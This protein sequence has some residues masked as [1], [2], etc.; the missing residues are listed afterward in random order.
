MFEEGTTPFSLSTGDF[1]SS[2][3]TSEFLVKILL[4]VKVLSGRFRPLDTGRC[5]SWL[6]QENVLICEEF[7]DF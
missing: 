2:V 6:V 1:N 3:K 4:V 5:W 7:L